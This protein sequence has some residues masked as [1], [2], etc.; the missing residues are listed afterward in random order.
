MQLIQFYLQENNLKKHGIYC[1]EE[2]YMEGIWGTIIFGVLLICFQLIPCNINNDIIQ[3]NFC[4][5]RKSVENFIQAFKDIIN[6][7]F[8]IYLELY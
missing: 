7:Y 1:L 2:I 3:N 8:I 4:G 6:V 5:S